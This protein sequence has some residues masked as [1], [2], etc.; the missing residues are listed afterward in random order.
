[1]QPIYAFGRCG[2]VAQ[3]LH[4]KWGRN[5]ALIAMLLLLLLLRFLVCGVTVRCRRLC[6]RL[7]PKPADNPLVHNASVM[8]QSPLLTVTKE[9]IRRCLAQLER[10]V[11]SVPFLQIAAFAPTTCLYT[12]HDRLSLVGAILWDNFRSVG[13][14]HFL[15]KHV[16]NPSH[17]TRKTSLDPMEW[18]LPW[19]Q[20]ERIDQD[21]V[22]FLMA[23]RGFDCDSKLFFDEWGAHD[24]HD[25][26]DVEDD[27]CVSATLFFCAV[28]EG[29]LDICRLLVHLHTDV[30]GDH[31]LHY[32]LECQ[33]WR[34]E[35]LLSPAIASQRPSV[36]ELL[37]RARADPHDRARNEYLVS[38]DSPN[39]SDTFRKHVT[40]LW[41]AVAACVED[42]QQ[43]PQE[44]ME[45]VR[46]L[47]EHRADPRRDS[48]LEYHI[49][50][51]NGLLTFLTD[52]SEGTP[53]RL[54]LSAHDRTG[55]HE[56]LVRLLDDAEG[57][58]QR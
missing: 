38:G 52:Q 47:L 23:M 44:A 31:F 35:T 6:A 29:M 25:E 42:E 41:Q 19:F 26:Y 4:A 51:T 3:L 34:R 18:C 43:A 16:E 48:S 1:M 45:I 10:R 57:P 33:P 54:A 50:D 40:P 56:E 55:Q 17:P 53:L 20:F 11:G 5:F 15:S 14:M 24:A 49:F 32:G 13:R 8:A 27:D 12:V 22:F 36:V 30:T 9:P 46:L 28:A 7:R 2:R 39:P 58:R 21:V 37:L